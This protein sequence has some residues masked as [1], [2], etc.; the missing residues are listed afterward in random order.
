MMGKLKSWPSTDRL[1]VVVCRHVEAEGLILTVT[2]IPSTNLLL[3]NLAI[4]Q[5]KHLVIRWTKWH[6]LHQQDN[7]RKQI[8]SSLL[9]WDPEVFTL[10]DSQGFKQTETLL[11]QEAK[12]KQQTLD[13]LPPLESIPEFLFFHNPKESQDPLAYEKSYASL[14]QWTLDS[15]DFYKVFSKTDSL[16]WIGTCPLS[17]LYS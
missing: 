9:I 8:N 4:F 16:V 10:S 7:H 14:R 2:S 17:P 5:K 15:I 12:I 13:E 1:C 6:R 3:R 11:R